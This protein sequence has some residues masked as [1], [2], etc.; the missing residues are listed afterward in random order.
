MNTNDLR[1]KWKALSQTETLEGY[2][3]AI[4][5]SKCAA[6]IFLG[7]NS[8][9]NHCMLLSLPK[10]YNLDFNT[11]KKERISITFYSQQHLLVLELHD[12]LY[13]DIF[14]DLIVSLYYAIKDIKEVDK[15][16][17]KIIQTFNRWSDFFEDE[18]TYL[19]SKEEVKGLYGELY[20]LKN[21]ITE[22]SSSSIDE[23]LSS[24]RG[25]Y[26]GPYDFVT[27]IKNI[28]VKTKTLTK[29]TV[30]IS[31][32]YQ[33]ENENNKGIEL[34]VLS[35]KEDIINGMS[36]RQLVE[37]I[38]TLV[39]TKSGDFSIVLKSLRQKHITQKNIIQ[40]DNH[41]FI[42]LE[43]IVYNC[44][45]GDFPRLV[46]SNTH[47]SITKIRYSLELTHLNAFILSTRRFDD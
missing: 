33:L 30:N 44:N 13:Y 20:V 43:Q 9:K 21:M 28:E 36:V 4:L 2:E 6:E 41:R 38:K 19:L 11:I 12:N 24:W 22:S 10:S 46:Q 1:N 42:A 25:L 7:V 3:S 14:D 47:S 40:Y 31:S 15:Y 26:D 29:N 17:R 16:T 8:L 27:D 23:I 37:K 5:S 32:E 34:L 18:S 45:C 39:F 35:V